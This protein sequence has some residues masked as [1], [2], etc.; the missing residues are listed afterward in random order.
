MA[1]GADRDA[2]ER[3]EIAFAF[4]VPQ[5]RAFAVGEGDRDAIVI[6]HQMIHKIFALP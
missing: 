3:V 6:I 1:Q 5:I 2:T 4:T